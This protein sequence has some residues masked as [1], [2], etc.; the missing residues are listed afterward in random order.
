VDQKTPPNIIEQADLR[1]R[2]RVFQDRAHA[3]EVVAE[4]LDPYCQ[5]DAMVLAIPAGGV[6]AGAVIA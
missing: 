1:E 6:P 2:T 3:G 4:M 5:T